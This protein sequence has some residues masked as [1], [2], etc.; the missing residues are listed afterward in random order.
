MHSRRRFLL[1]RAERDDEIGEVHG[2][3]AGP[4]LEGCACFPRGPVLLP[5]APGVHCVLALHHHHGLAG[6]DVQVADAE[7]CESR[8]DVQHLYLGSLPRVARALQQAASD[9]R[10]LERVVLEEGV[11]AHAVALDGDEGDACED[12]WGCRG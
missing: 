3:G 8:G 6:L 12:A 5:G 11:L 7:V 4:E 2:W 10:G 9:G 1:C